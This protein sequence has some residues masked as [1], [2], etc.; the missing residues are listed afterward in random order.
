MNL[1]GREGSQSARKPASLSD[2][3]HRPHFGCFGNVVE[4]CVRT[5]RPLQEIF[6]WRIAS[7]LACLDPWWCLSVCVGSSVTSP[8]CR[9]RCAVQVAESG[10]GEP[11]LCHYCVLALRN[12]IVS[13]GYRS[14]SVKRPAESGK[15]C[16]PSNST[17]L[18][19]LC[20]VQLSTPIER[21]SVHMQQCACR[22]HQ[23]AMR[24]QTSDASE[25]S[26]LLQLLL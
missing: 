4:R 10:F 13:R 26:V 8:A 12:P 18:P 15:V 9:S 19:R 1:I 5:L 3:T 17:T 25:D 16:T 2:S 23:C 11:P 6:W 14:P 24:R 7:A 21:N 20:T 22:L